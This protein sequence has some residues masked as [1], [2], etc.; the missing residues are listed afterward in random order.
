MTDNVTNSPSK[1]KIMKEKDLTNGPSKLC[2]A[3]QINK[4]LFNKV[5]L[6]TSGDMWLEEDVE[7]DADKVVL[8][9]R[10][11]IGY[12]EEWT[13]KPLRFYMLGNP[14]VSVRNKE[15]EATCRG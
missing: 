13:D 8:S 7:V 1:T 14:F 3:L 6:V 5:D 10:I 15:C 2:Q 4:I 9:P 11:N 12:A